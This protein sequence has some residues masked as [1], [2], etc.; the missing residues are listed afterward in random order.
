M[1]QFIG[2]LS[3]GEHGRD[4]ALVQG[5]NVDVQ[6]TADSGD[7][8]GILWVIRH[9][10]RAAAGQQHIGAVVHGNIVGDVVDQRGFLADILKNL[11]IH[12]FLLLRTERKRPCMAALSLLIA[13]RYGLSVWKSSVEAYWPPLTPEHGFPSL[14]YK[15]QG[16][17]P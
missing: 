6:S 8:H 15:A 4:G 12:G 17:P 10:G 13:D 14:S 11:I 9:N 3:G 5:S 1:A 2:P 7:L 16:A